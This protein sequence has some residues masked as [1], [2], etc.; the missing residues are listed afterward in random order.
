MEPI[1]GYLI[2]LRKDKLL[3]RL[4]KQIK[5]SYKLS[6]AGMREIILLQ[7]LHILKV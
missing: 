1:A 5:R 6:I 3:A 7:I 2:I 4:I